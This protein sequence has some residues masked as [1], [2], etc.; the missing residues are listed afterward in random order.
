MF[1]EEVSTVN[2]FVYRFLTKRQS[3]E[4]A[5]VSATISSKHSYSA[6]ICPQGRTESRRSET[7]VL[8]PWCEYGGPCAKFAMVEKSSRIAAALQLAA[9]QRN[10]VFME[11]LT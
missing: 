6:R 5:T 2:P 7:A 8:L 11:M 1:V 10:V 3:A 9:Y 4:I